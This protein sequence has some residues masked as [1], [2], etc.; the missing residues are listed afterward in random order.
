MSNIL[1]NLIDFSLKTYVLII[2]YMASEKNKD[3]KE[4]Y[5]K[6]VQ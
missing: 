1:I 4:K 6:F 5:L 2:L 3:N